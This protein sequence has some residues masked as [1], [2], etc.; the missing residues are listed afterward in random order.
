MFHGFGKTLGIAIKKLLTDFAPDVVV[1][2]GGIS[3]SAALFLEDVEAEL[4]D[5]HMEVRVAEL[6]DNAPLAGAGVAWFGSV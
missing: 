1:L 4:V 3:R 6:G 2:G 5:T